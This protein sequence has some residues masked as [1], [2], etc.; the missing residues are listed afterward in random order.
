M[1]RIK[2]VIKCT[3]VSNEN[4]ESL[5]NNSKNTVCKQFLTYKTKLTLESI[6]NVQVFGGT[7]SII[8]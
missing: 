5:K 1:L 3:Y 8:Y 4:I 2:G 6:E 7:R